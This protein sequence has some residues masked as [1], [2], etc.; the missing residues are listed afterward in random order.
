MLKMQQSV[1]W[2]IKGAKLQHLLKLLVVK[3]S[4][5]FLVQLQKFQIIVNGYRVLFL[6]QNVCIAFKLNLWM[7]QKMPSTNLV[8]D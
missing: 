8:H 2:K 4:A 7:Q 3:V 5:L 1:P 6:K